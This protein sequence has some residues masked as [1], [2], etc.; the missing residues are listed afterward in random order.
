MLA[1]LPAGV[2]LYAHFPAGHP[3]FAK[4]STHA[5]QIQCNPYGLREAPCLWW[6]H[7]IQ[8]IKRHTVL[9]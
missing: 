7:S 4:T 8:T 3:D 9:K 5:L 2:T 6:K 1:V